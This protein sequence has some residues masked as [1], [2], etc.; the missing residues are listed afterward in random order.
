MISLSAS[1][2]TSKTSA[3]LKAMQSQS[4]ISDLHGLAERGVVALSQATPKDSSLTANSWGY[5]IDQSNGGIK[6][7]W[8]N[9]NSEDGVNVAVILQYGHGTGTGGYVAGRDYINPAIKPVMDEI[10]DTV[11]KKVRSS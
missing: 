4:L 3:F 6:I 8:F 11:W 5:E 2:S 9:T 1:G 10:A 7:T